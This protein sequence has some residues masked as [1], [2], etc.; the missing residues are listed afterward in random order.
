MDFIRTAMGR[1]LLEGTL[2][3]IAKSLERIAT[4]LE[5]QNAEKAPT[6]GDDADLKTILKRV[7]GM[8]LIPVSHGGPHPYVL[9]LGSLPDDDAPRYYVF[10]RIRSLAVGW[11]IGGH[12]TTYLRDCLLTDGVTV[13]VVY[14]ALP[15]HG[16]DAA[17]TR[18]VTWANQ[19][20][21]AA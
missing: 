12:G 5:A 10:T 21:K 13:S 2:P 16:E 4:A 15:V 1:T 6:V 14:T 9:A 19:C 8:G 3:R 11:S 17:L 20:K 7:E 18:A